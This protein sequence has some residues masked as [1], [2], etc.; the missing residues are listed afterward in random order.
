M[1]KKQYQIRLSDYELFVLK[2]IADL[3]GGT[4]TSVMKYALYAE[5]GDHFIALKEDFESIT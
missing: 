3:T 1:P 2:E 4:V 5:Y